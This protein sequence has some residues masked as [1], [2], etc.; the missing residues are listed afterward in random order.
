[1]GGLTRCSPVSYDKQNT[2][3]MSGEVRER[4]ARRKCD[5]GFCGRLE[6]YIA[7]EDFRSEARTKE[8]A[9]ESLATTLLWA[10]TLGLTTPS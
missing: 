3:E 8:L 10:L 1:M 6:N 9:D 2:T 7:T 4:H 5:H